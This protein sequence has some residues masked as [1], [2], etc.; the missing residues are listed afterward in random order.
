MTAE[1]GAHRAP[2]QSWVLKLGH[3]PKFYRRGRGCVPSVSVREFL[4]RRSRSAIFE[5]IETRSRSGRS[6]FRRSALRAANRCLERTALTWKKI[7]R[8]D[9]AREAPCQV[10]SRQGQR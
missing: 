5:F 10:M 3:D 7:I 6:A 2:L 4:V 9:F 8:V 1:N